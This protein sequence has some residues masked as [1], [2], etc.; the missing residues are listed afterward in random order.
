MVLATAVVLTLLVAGGAS[1]AAAI[2]LRPDRPDKQLPLGTKAT[3]RPGERT[4]IKGMGC[5]PGSR[6]TIRLD[7]RTLGT[8]TA[9][10]TSSIPGV[11]GWFAAQVTIPAGT[12]PG[13]HTLSAVCPAPRGVGPYLKQDRTTITVVRS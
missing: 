6:V 7:G 10:A 1:A 12:P 8:T 2:V 11:V 13:P 5:R 4:G 3:L 9:E